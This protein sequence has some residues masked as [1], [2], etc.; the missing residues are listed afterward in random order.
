LKVDKYGNQ[1]ATSNAD[2]VDEDQVTF[3]F[4]D[5]AVSLEAEI[6]ALRDLARNIADMTAVRHEAVSP[7]PLARVIGFGNHTLCVCGGHMVQTSAESAVAVGDAFS[8]TATSLRSSVVDVADVRVHERKKVSM[9]EGVRFGV[10]VLACAFWRV[11]VG[12]C[13]H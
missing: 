6:V 7:L 2:D 9:I 12:M 13:T 4:R 10:C 1:A 8:V 5:S 3:H 11:R